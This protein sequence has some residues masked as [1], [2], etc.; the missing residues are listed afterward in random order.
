MLQQAKCKNL[1]G[2]L[3]SGLVGALAFAGISFILSIVLMFVSMFVYQ[4]I[5]WLAYV[6]S[7]FS[8]VF[9]LSMAFPKTVFTVTG[10][11]GFILGLILRRQFPAIQ[12]GILPLVIASILLVVALGWRGWLL[13]K[14]WMNTEL[15]S[16]SLKLADCTNNVVNIHLKIP[17][18]HDYQLDLKTPETRVLMGGETNVAYTFYGHLRISSNGLLIADLPIS[19]DTAWQWQNGWY[20]LTGAG[21]RN[22][23]VPP[24][25][26]FI[27][28]NKSYDFEIRFETLPPTN[29]SI[30]LYCLQSVK[31]I[32]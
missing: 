14:M 4:W 27:Q 32:N 19:S 7:W 22:T 13:H 10:S 9:L 5:R 1:T 24:L 15:P 12:R 31:D 29:A 20:G 2:M 23:N 17:A 21:M 18:G 28:S 8:C 3:K 30:W 25:S 6:L 26:R 16:V 11:I